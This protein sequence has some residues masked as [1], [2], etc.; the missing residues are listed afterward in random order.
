MASWLLSALLRGRGA[1]PALL[2]LPVG[3]VRG[4]PVLCTW[5]PRLG[6]ALCCAQQRAFC[7]FVL[8]FTWGNH[9]PVPC[10]LL[11]VWALGGDTHL[12]AVET[13]PIA[14]PIPTA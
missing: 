8:P 3:E 9:E 13:R 4:A 7:L 14:T 10:H 11:F 12:S 6:V 2:P 5:R 1:V